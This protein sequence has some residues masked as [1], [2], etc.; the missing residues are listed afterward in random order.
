[1]FLHLSVILF[2]G[3]GVYFSMQWAG[4]VYTSVG[5]PPIPETVT[6]VGGTHPTGMHS[7]IL[8]RSFFKMVLDHAIHH[9]SPG[10]VE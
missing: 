5:R 3:E 2:T 4:G 1:M 7:C 6:E 10:Y 8:L 9:A